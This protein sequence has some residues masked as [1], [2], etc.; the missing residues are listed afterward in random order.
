MAPGGEVGTPPWPFLT[1]SLVQGPGIDAGRLTVSLA[2][3]LCPRAAVKPAT[4]V[5]KLWASWK[6]VMMLKAGRQQ[7][8]QGRREVRLGGNSST[9]RK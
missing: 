8:Q 4:F 1:A 6:L 2:E 9:G 5:F 3:S 7:G